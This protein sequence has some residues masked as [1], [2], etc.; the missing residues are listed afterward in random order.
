MKYLKLLIITF[1]IFLINPVDILAKEQVDLYLFYSD[2]C[3]HCAKE[4]IFLEKIK[5]EYDNLSIHLYEVSNEE[6]DKLLTEVKKTLKSEN[7]YVPYT[8]I[9]TK[10][11]TGYNDNIGSQ[12]EATIKYYSDKKHRDIVGEIVGTSTKPNDDEII[13]D[14]VIGDGFVTIPLL[15]EIDPKSMSLPLI[16]VIIGTID[17]F[18]PCAMWVLL[19]LISMLLGMK[20][21]K[22]M[23]ALGL[24]F[25]VTSALMYLLLMVAWLQI[26]MSISSIAWVKILIALVA[27]AGG[28]F[29]LKSYYQAL[30]KETGCTVVDDNKRKK[31]FNRIKSFTT[32][33]SFLLALL[34]VMALAVSVNLVE[35]ACSAGLPLLFT[36]ILALNDLSSLQYCTYIL[37]YILFF[38]IDDIII[39]SIAM[40]TLKLTGISNK[41]SKYSHLIG[42]IIMLIIGVLL[43]MKPEW[44]MFNF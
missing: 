23:W 25:L 37:I 13:D 14:E 9:G 41:Y 16:A 39:F 4:K 33:K 17:G 42:G 12:I 19:F 11:Y 18:N 22:R 5:S 34:G 6:N 8:V 35:L 31:I 27:L 10:A 43:I 7:P 29:N 36:Q 38:L 32:Q 21:R 15:G 26:S 30:K 44:L 2:A 3:P 20:D 1:I 24:T 40:F 28:I